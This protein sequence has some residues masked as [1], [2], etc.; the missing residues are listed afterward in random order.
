MCSRPGLGSRGFV[1]ARGSR[2]GEGG[3]T[4]PARAASSV[5]RPDARA[6]EPADREPDGGAHA[7]HLSLPAFVDRDLE[8][9]P[10]PGRGCTSADAR[11]LRSCRRRARH[12]PASARTS[13]L[14]GISFDLDEVR[15]LDAVARMREQLREIAVVR[16]EQEALGVD[17]EPADGEHAGV[18]GH[19]LDAPSVDPADRGRSSRRREA[20]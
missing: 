19:E 11:R 9:T 16:E 6:H 7:S 2:S 3:A 1:R 10:R 12:R 8:R 18:V 13:V 15:L 14:G 5:Q 20:C 4:R 17:V